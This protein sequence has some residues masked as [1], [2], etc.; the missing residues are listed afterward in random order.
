VKGKTKQAKLHERADR[1]AAI[2]YGALIK[3]SKEEQEAA[4]NAVQNTKIL[5]RT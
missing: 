5:N 2:M 4:I 3:L 1:V